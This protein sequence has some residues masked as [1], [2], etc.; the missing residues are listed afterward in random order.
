MEPEQEP[1][2][3][4]DQQLFR[5]VK[6][7][8]V[9]LARQLLLAGANIDAVD[10]DG[11]TCLYYALQK[12]GLRLIKFLLDA[13][14]DPNKFRLGDMHP[15]S[16]GVAT[17]KLV[18]VKDLIDAGARINMVNGTSEDR[19][20]LHVAVERGRTEIVQLLLEHGADVNAFDADLSSVIVT[21]IIRK[22]KFR[23]GDKAYIDILK[24]LLAHGADTS[25]P[26][27]DI[28]PCD[29]D[30]NEF[31]YKLPPMPLGAVLQYGNVEALKL[32]LD[33]GLDL[34]SVGPRHYWDDTDED[35]EHPTHRALRN[36]DTT[37]LKY[38]LD[39]G[40]CNV[41]E[42]DYYGFEAI[43]K[44]VTSRI[45][46]AHAKILLK[47]G[48]D[49]NVRSRM[50]ETPLSKAI[51]A[52]CVPGVQLL[53]DY[54]ADVNKK[55][56]LGDHDV[57]YLAS[58]CRNRNDEVFRCMLKVMAIWELQGRKIDHLDSK[59]LHHLKP[60][61]MQY[62]SECT[63]EVKSMKRYLIYEPLSY[64]DLLV[65][66]DL[67][68]YTKDSLVI[69]ALI[70]HSERIKSFFQIY[71]GDLCERFSKAYMKAKVKD[72]AERKLSR[73]IGIDFDRF[74]GILRNI[75]K[76]LH[77]K[78]LQSLCNVSFPSN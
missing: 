34:K 23:V 73:L 67:S 40:L 65:C 39:Q 3:S 45:S 28:E 75:L 50:L 11:R 41:A 15:L 74:R 42:K 33:Q 2:L 1:E 32:F 16:M 8:N 18:I 25:E 76:R 51:G 5:A 54:D 77:K 48:A 58:T 29:E 22:K 55:V 72:E 49:P 52:E 53:L 61:C 35:R 63:V 12:K 9:L 44:A 66:K 4:N 70:N 69:D 36:P 21:A 13:G 37:V 17:G 57:V 14:A 64:F 10:T 59:I 27:Y 6:T 31:H 60:D 20:A 26:E 19:S 71:G 68:R 56:T 78:D 30:Y 7:G 62:F 46:I 43:H 38:L 47:R 24:L